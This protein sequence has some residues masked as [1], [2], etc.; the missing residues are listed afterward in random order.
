MA[1]DLDFNGKS[2]L[3]VGLRGSGKTYLT[4]AIAKQ[5]ELKPV[6]VIDMM[7]SFDKDSKD[8]D[9]YIPTS[10]SYSDASCKECNQLI[11]MIY[12]SENYKGKTYRTLIFDD[13][14]LW[15]PPMKPLPSQ[16]MWLNNMQGKH[17]NLC[18]KDKGVCT[19]YTTRKP[20]NINSQVR[21]IIDYIIIFK[22]TGKNDLRWA[23]DTIEGIKER[24]KELK[25]YEFLVIDSQGNITKFNPI[26]VDVK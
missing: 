15:M 26:K 24:V 10:K 2:I 14:D 1:L 3:I 13:C 25:T 6:L 12:K 16:M 22:M 21:D 9:R 8:Y 17:H 19:I 20:T 11:T 4:K 5:P 23:E 18:G 7:N